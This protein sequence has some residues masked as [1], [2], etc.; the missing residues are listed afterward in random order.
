M[1]LFVYPRTISYI[2]WRNQFLACRARRRRP[3]GNDGIEGLQ[4]PFGFSCCP[5]EHTI[6]RV[7]ATPA[8]GP[9]GGEWKP[10]S[11]GFSTS[12][13]AV[14]KLLST[15]MSDAST[16]KQINTW[17]IIPLMHFVILINKRSKS[18]AVLSSNCSLCFCACDW[19]WDEVDNKF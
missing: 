8:A 18:S 6:G 5:D 3:A 13:S 17:I 16:T 4:Y 7:C 12:W 10:S 11:S 2:R 1:I 14:T 19:C 9:S 15:L